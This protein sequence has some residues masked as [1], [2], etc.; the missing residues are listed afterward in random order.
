MRY[1]LWNTR[2]QA[3]FGWEYF[4]AVL[5]GEV[6]D[7]L[8]PFHGHYFLVGPGIVQVLSA[9]RTHTNQRNAPFLK[10]H[11]GNRR[12]K[13]CRSPP[14]HYVRRIGPGMP[15][16]FDGYIKGVYDKPLGSLDELLEVFPLVT[17]I[18]Y[19]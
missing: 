7:E 11:S 8:D 17:L 18:S 5:V 12:S 13:A 16:Q 3:H 2:R 1:L 14:A 4:P 19:S 10:V 15:D 9:G 6:L